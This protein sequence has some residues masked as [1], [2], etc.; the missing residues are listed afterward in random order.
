[1]LT[2]HIL[3][4]F[5]YTYLMCLYLCISDVPHG[6][7][8]KELELTSLPSEGPHAV[9]VGG[10]S[11]P[12]LSIQSPFRYL[13]ATAAGVMDISRELTLYVKSVTT[14]KYKGECI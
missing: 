4:L 6:I 11:N 13:C 5:I 12:D 1:M 3:S 14:T 2:L 8:N 9:R 7:R 10:E